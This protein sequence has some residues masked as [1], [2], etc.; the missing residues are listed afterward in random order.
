MLRL[1]TAWSQ[2]L[3]LCNGE[4]MF[5]FP[6]DQDSEQGRRRND[7]G[8][9]GLSIHEDVATSHEHKH[10]MADD[11]RNSLLQSMD[12]MYYISRK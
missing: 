6:E 8:H 5:R 3:W 1:T 12:D 4:N 2:F 7:K 9:V 11:Q 10:L